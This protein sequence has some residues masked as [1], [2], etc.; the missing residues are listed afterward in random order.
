[1]SA[2]TTP[3]AGD[4]AEVAASLQPAGRHALAAA[5][6]GWHVFPLRG[7]TKLPAAR[8]WENA[9]TTDVERI[10]R[11]WAKHPGDGYGIACGPSDLFVV[12]L[13]DKDGHNGTGEWF[14]LRDRHNAT[15][16]ATFTVGTPSG[17]QHLYLTQPADVQLRS[18]AGRLGDGIDTRGHGG[19]VV[20]PG[21]ELPNG[22]YEVLLDDPVVECPWWLAELLVPPTRKVTSAVRVVGRST[23]YGRAAIER[24]CGAIALA[25]DGQRNHTL[26]RE[27]FGL[28]QLVAGGEVE[29]AEAVTALEVAATRAGL[30]VEEAHQTIASGMKAGTRSPRSAP[31]RRGGGRR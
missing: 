29:V 18:S 1:M 17:G 16:P 20:G 28:G 19:Y 5:A 21:V 12:D 14:K 8:D 22:C 11:W 31:A 26:N 4:V 23:P 6:R 10:T 2:D 15:G 27:A 13:D 25:P 3:V 30:S 7:G 9:A 24:G